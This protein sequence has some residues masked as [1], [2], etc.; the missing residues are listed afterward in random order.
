[1]KEDWIYINEKLPAELQNVLVTINYDNHVHIAYLKNGEWKIWIDDELVVRGDA[2]IENR[3]TNQK[4]F[5]VIA[6]MELPA[7]AKWQGD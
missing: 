6:W 4:G 3:I 7:Y 2:W 1:M 5:G